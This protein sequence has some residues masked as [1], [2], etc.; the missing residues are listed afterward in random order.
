LIQLFESPDDDKANALDQ[1][2]EG[3]VLIQQESGPR[4]IRLAFV[5]SKDYDP[6][7]KVKNPK[8]YLAQALSALTNA[9]PNKFGTMIQPLSDAQKAALAKYLQ[10]AQVTLR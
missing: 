1:D 9:H 7:A 5:P 4:F 8:E 6:C 2:E 3:Q 10:A